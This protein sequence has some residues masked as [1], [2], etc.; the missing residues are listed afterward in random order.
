MITFRRSDVEHQILQEQ[1]MAYLT[2]THELREY[3]LYLQSYPCKAACL[4]A[5]DC[6]S[7]VQQ[8]LLEEAKQEW[9]LVQQLESHTQSSKKLHSNCL[10]VGFRCYREILTCLEKADFQ[11]NQEVRDTVAAW[12]PCFGQSANLEQVFREMEHAIKQGGA[13]QDNLS[14]MACVAV[15]AMQ[16]RVCAGSGTPATVTLG[17]AD[18]CGHVVRGLKER[19]WNPSAAVPSFLSVRS[20]IPFTLKLYLSSIF[21]ETRTEVPVSSSTTS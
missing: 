11:M 8:R 19:L 13:P 15:R 14:N 21:H 9:L 20:H 3:L 6:P 16:R 17:D 18:W 1:L 4:I 2:C 5:K 12:Y 7:A 10:Y